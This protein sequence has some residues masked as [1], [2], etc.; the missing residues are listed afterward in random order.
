METQ[1]TGFQ[2][3]LNDGLIVQKSVFAKGS[4]GVKGEMFESRGGGSTCQKLQITI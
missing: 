4:G 3:L 2:H 1:Q